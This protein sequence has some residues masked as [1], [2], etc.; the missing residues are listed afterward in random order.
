MTDNEKKLKAQLDAMTAMQSRTQMQLAAINHRMQQQPQQQHNDIIEDEVFDSTNYFP[1]QQQQV[2][3]QQQLTPNQLIMQGITQ[4]AAAQAANMVYNH[5]QQ[6]QAYTD[7]VKERMERL[8]GDYPALTDEGSDLVNKA[9]SIYQRVERE[10]PGLD[11]ATKYE[12][13]VREAAS[14]LGAR[15]VTLAPEDA[16]WT[17]GNQNNNPSMPS[18]KSKSRLTPEILANAKLMGIDVDPKS[19]AGQKN[20]AELSE[21]SARFNADQNESH[22]KYR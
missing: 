14:N 21:Y 11:N 12:L 4:N 10:N 5:Q 19:Q 8:V 16:G 7:S 6:T 18:K 13:A 3:Q 9:R 2:P 20:L 17:M 22:V 1:Q 15:P